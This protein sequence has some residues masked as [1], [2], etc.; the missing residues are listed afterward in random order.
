M[1]EARELL[2]TLRDIGEPPAPL[3]SPPLLIVANAV[4]AA[5]IVAIV[6]HRGRRRRRAWLD[7]SLEAVEQALVLPP[8]EGRLALARVLR[9]VMR[10]RHGNAV[11]ALHG[12]PWLARLDAEF[13][14]DWFTRGEGRAF[15]DALY[16]P[17]G[18]AGDPAEGR[19]SAG[20]ANDVGR[21]GH[22]LARRLKRLPPV[23]KE[24][25]RRTRDESMP[26][27][28]EREAPAPGAAEHEPANGR[29]GRANAVATE[30]AR[31]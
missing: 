5:L 30:A 25:K 16:A 14:G 10:H 1:S 13:G 9:R 17:T 27:P 18:R 15:G 28:M 3:G 12:K 23:P 4:L 21:L 19:S 11:D 24:G 7:E 2:A 29:P 8:P 26:V 31:R 20:G 6:V 22:E